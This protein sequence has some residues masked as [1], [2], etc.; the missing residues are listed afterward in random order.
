[1]TDKCY[2]DK[3]NTDL[4]TVD[5]P[6]KRNNNPIIIIIIIIIIMY[7]VYNFEQQKN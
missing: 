2:I 1:M 5:S 6:N 3:G 4:Q 7:G